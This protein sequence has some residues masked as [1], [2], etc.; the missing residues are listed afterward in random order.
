MQMAF[1]DPERERDEAV[2]LLRE[3]VT[4]YGYTQ[5]APQGR[6]IWAR[7]NRFLAST[8]SEGKA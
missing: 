5:V 2:A 4:S 7:V 3:L 8:V 6:G 1:R